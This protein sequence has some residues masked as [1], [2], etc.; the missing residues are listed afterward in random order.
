M[1]LELEEVRDKLSQL[2]AHN[3]ALEEQ[4]RALR[5]GME[6]TAA[7]SS[8]QSRAA[9]SSSAQSDSAAVVPA[10]SGVRPKLPPFWCERPA[11]WFAHI[12]AQFALSAIS[13]DE[14]KYNYVVAQIDSNLS[15]EVEDL[16]VNPPPEG[17]RYD[18]IKAE[19]IQRFTASEA[20]R[21]RQLLSGEELGD[22]KPTQFLRH[23]RQLAGKSCSE[24]KIFRELWL[25]RLPVNVQA[26][27]T[28]QGELPLDKV[29]ELADKILEVNTVSSHSVHAIEPSKQSLQIIQNQ[30]LDLGKQ[31]A[32]LASAQQH[33][34]RSRSRSRSTPRSRSAAPMCWYHRRFSAKAAKC[35]KP[36]SWSLSENQ[37]SSQ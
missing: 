34:P 28:A 15:R 24:E 25:Q 18:W 36:C 31:V 26:I 8:A 3:V 10:V 19:M 22:R 1:E 12:E 32:A 29:A 11:S 30:L 23:L 35:I 6:R 14:T 17:N 16:V 37:A 21:A 9:A 33:G 27:L 13:R 2:L 20:Q 7:S 5:L 4:N